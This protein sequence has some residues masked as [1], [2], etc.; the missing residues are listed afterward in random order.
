[1]KGDFS[2]YDEQISEL[3]RK[4]EQR[5]K[6]QRGLWSSFQ[7]PVAKKPHVEEKEAVIEKEPNVE[8]KDS[9]VVAPQT[10]S[11]APAPV[12]RNSTQKQDRLN[13]DIT[14]CTTE[15]NALK[16]LLSGLKPR[17]DYRAKIK[18]LDKKRDKLT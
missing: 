12:T 9:E 1:M 15:I 16:T 13:A 11:P 14:R 6:R 2:A 8:E 3:K 18:M 5:L 10:P 17:A 7:Q 4:R